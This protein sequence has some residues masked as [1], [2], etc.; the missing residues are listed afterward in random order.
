MKNRIAIGIL[1]GVFICG[2]ALA[3]VFAQGQF[4]RSTEIAVPETDLNN[5]GTGNMVSGVDLDNDG[6]TEIYLV[7]DNWNDTATEVVP[8]IYKIEQDGANWN[9]VWQ[10]VAPVEKQNT[11]PTLVVGD[12]DKDGKKEVIW[13]PVNNTSGVTNLNPFRVLVYEAKGDGSDVMGVPDGAGGYL[14]N[15]AWKIA[16][17][18]SKNIRPMRWVVADP[19]NDGTDELIFAERAGR[20]GGYFFGV[21]SVSNIP[22]NGDG[23]ETWTLEVSGLDFGLLAGTTQNKWD[24]AVIGGNVY[25]FCEIEVSKLWWDGGAWQFDS[26]K[27]MKGGASV[28]SAQVVDLDSDGVQEIICAV[29]DWGEDAFKGIYLLQEEADT[30]K[31]TELVNMTAYWPGG[32]RGPWGGACGDIDQDG[33]LDFVF[34]SRASTPNAAIFNLSYR[35]GDIT[36]PASYTFAM[37]DSLYAE[38]G[39]WTVVNIANVD[40]DPELEVLYTSSTDAGVFPNLGTK[41]IIVLDYVPAAGPSF[42]KLV[43]A[44]EVLFNGATPPSDF[45]FKPGR[46]LD[47]G[48]TIWFCAASTANKVSY[49]FR[50]I[51]GGKTFTHNA[52][53]INERAAQMDA[54]DANTAL[55]AQA[56]G[57]IYKTIDG[58]V[59]WVEKHAYTISV[60]APGWFDG[61]RVLNDNVA[62]AYGDMEPSGNMYFVRTEDKGETWTQITGIDYLG[63]A[64][65]YYTWGLAACNIGENIWCTATNTEYTASFLFRSD[66]AGLTWE[67]YEIPT[68][69]IPNYPRSVAFSD[70]YNGM[71][72]ARGGY[73]VKTEDGGEIWEATN[74]PDS[75]A[76]SY[77]NGVVAIPNTDII[78]AMDDLGV[79]YTTDLGET[80]GKMELPVDL[81]DDYTAGLFL[82]TEFGYVFT[83]NGQVLR[84]E[85]QIVGV[86]EHPRNNVANDFHLSQNYPNPFNPSTTI[87]YN[88][89]KSEHV[90][91]KIYN[92]L[93]HEVKTL[94]DG[95]EN[96]GSHSVMWDGTD[97]F[98]SKVTSGIY[99]YSIRYNDKLMTKRMMLVK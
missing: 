16:T 44:P 31:R 58:G 77:V 49:V 10:A 3:D 11:W 57:K 40:A 62:V 75:S 91:L 98:G 13:G 73:V 28:Q 80:W 2:F 95:V 14:P 22:D 5:G 51:D 20:T 66:D 27:P 38:G 41:P 12:L 53:P 19:D 86:S 1:I 25:T 63:S 33:K 50:S 56:D 79:Y 45:L 7:N 68:D 52:T 37:I 9:V 15:S 21:A 99:I 94:I 90:T 26:L 82:N 23:S 69:V 24:V 30:L 46:I 96:A 70:V 35:G 78:L 43:I 8:R 85:D 6:K 55:I 39:I 83:Y 4:V 89:P 34:G 18:D 29:Y 64:Y 17:E 61:L 84:F 48:N 72:A 60:I 81:D 65:A 87:V 71:I 93:G 67:S 74:N 76:D 47:N 32:S 54:F 42:G 97:N 59:T 36:A 88:L 92:L